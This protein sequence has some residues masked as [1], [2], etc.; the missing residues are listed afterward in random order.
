M[1]SSLFDK[2]VI[3]I[4]GGFYHT[5]VLVKNK[6]V[7]EMSK[8]STDMRKI[9][10]EPT[11]SDVT[12]LVEGKPVHSHRIIIMARCKRLHEKIKQQGI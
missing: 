9:I 10:N 8:L 5:I 12:F 3:D 7:R 2:K 11:R 1:I 6:K 4:A